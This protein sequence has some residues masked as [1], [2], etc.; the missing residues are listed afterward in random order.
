MSFK[1]VLR[2][3]YLVSSEEF[4]LVQTPTEIGQQ[5]SERIM[6]MEPEY[7]VIE[8]FG[9]MEI[10]FICRSK[11]NYKDRVFTKTF[12]LTSQEEEAAINSKK[13][14]NDYKP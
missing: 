13:N 10:K 4:A 1:S 2:K 8:P 7:G 12:A 6:L 5:Q 14:S 3:G 11:V 9:Q